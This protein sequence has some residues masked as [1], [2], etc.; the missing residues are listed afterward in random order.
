MR[1]SIDLYNLWSYGSGVALHT[2]NLLTCAQ[3][4]QKST[5]GAGRIYRIRE[6]RGFLISSFSGLKG[7]VPGAESGGHRNGISPWEA[8]RGSRWPG[9]RRPT[10]ASLNPSPPPRL[11]GSGPSFW[12]ARGGGTAA[13]GA[14][15]GGP[16]GTVGLGLAEEPLAEARAGKTPPGRDARG[17]ASALG[18]CTSAAPPRLLGAPPPGPLSS[19]RR[20]RGGSSSLPSL[21]GRGGGKRWMRAP[22]ARVAER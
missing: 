19:P 3:W 6:P 8:G 12:R 9:C 11:A 5:S 20:G 10:Y 13:V 16:P 14:R 2:W 18:W 22:T 4:L 15:R 21:S 17:R 7:K 1:E